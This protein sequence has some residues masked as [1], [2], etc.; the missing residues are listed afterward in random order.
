MTLRDNIGERYEKLKQSIERDYD[1]IN[2][3]QDH[4]DGGQAFVNNSQNY[5]YNISPKNLKLSHHALSHR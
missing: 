5:D 1:N 4:I 2:N 3:C